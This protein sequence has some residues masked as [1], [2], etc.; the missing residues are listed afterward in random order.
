VTRSSVESEYRVMTSTA[1]ELTWIKQHLVDMNITS[2]TPMKIFCDNQATKYITSNLVFRERTKYIEIDC[3]F[4]RE[5]NYKLRK[6]RL[7]SYKVKI[8]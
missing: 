4:M 3:H 2:A 8:N 5:K 7:N 6:L 1:N